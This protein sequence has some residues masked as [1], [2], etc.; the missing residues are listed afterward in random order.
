MPDLIPAQPGPKIK[1]DYQ[2]KERPQKDNEVNPP[3]TNLP[4]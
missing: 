4:D 2:A 3:P 1:Q